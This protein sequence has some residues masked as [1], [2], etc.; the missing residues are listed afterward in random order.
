[1]LKVLGEK[2]V[3]DYSWPVLR[4]LISRFS[5]FG[6]PHRNKGHLPYLEQY[7]DHPLAAT[8]PAGAKPCRFPPRTIIVEPGYVDKDYLEDYSAYYAKC[9]RHRDE[10]YKR[11]CTRLHLFGARITEARLSR[12]ITEPPALDAFKLAESLKYIGFIVV[13]PL[14][15]KFI[16]RTCLI[17]YEDDGLRNYTA[18][19]QYKV[20]LYGI[21]LTIETLAYQEQDGV[22]GACATS[23]LWVCFQQTSHLFQHT[24]PKTVEITNNA[25]IASLGKQRA[26]PSLGMNLDQVVQAVRNAGLEPDMYNPRNLNEALA[27]AYAYLRCKIP[28]LASVPLYDIKDVEIL[29]QPQQHLCLNEHEMHAVALAGYAHTPGA[30]GVYVIDNA[31]GQDLELSLTGAGIHKLYAHDDQIGPFARLVNDGGQVSVIKRQELLEELRRTAKDE[32]RRRA[33]RDA[34]LATEEDQKPAAKEETLA[35]KYNN[36]PANRLKWDVEWKPSLAS[37]WGFHIAEMQ[38][39]RFGISSLI[40]PVDRKIRISFDKVIGYVCMLENVLKKYRR[41]FLDPA[42]HGAKPA[43]YTWDIF[44]N[45]SNDAKLD[46]KHSRVSEDEKLRLLLAGWPKYIWRACVMIDTYKIIEFVFDAT[47]L[48]F[49]D[50][51]IQHI[52]YDKEFAASF[53]RF[54]AR[55][56]AVGG[57]D[58]SPQHR[59]MLEQILGKRIVPPST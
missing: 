59:R 9:Y 25:I 47:E 11:F 45:L 34:E 27:I 4:G 24:A 10:G 23:A 37:S 18:V 32:L 38:N 33:E 57:K 51:L 55:D 41:E 30:A 52:D 29:N 58:I 49:S 1:M 2:I 35:E 15:E 7:L 19:R 53:K 6:P 12:Y 20:S 39:S 16:G 50:C 42:S 8:P 21:P 46:I 22:V 28:V 14:P 43:D 56:I 44:L 26:L 3:C 13:R 48:D 54:L 17:P 5:G 31:R 40:I 36:L